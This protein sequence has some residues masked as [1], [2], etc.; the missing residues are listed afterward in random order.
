MHLRRVTVLTDRFPSRE[1]YPFNLPVLQQTALLDFERPVTFF[2]GENGSGKSTFLRG[3]AEA[4]GIY[5][6]GGERRARFDE[7]PYEGSLHRYLRV[8]WGANRV[9]GS[10]FAAESF[11]SFRQILDEW[12]T[13]DPELLEDFGSRSLMSQSH[14]QSHMAYFANRY[15]LEGI[16]FLDEP[17]NA[18]SPRRQLE[19]LEI[20]KLNAE[21]GRAQFLVA[22]HSPVLLACPGAAVL[23]FDH[24]PVQPVRYEDTDHYRVYKDLFRR[25]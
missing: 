16:Y 20:L 9:P 24:V 13:A 8:H 25:D 5:I 18:L 22:T 15:R 23:S 12:A 2:V 11:R 4:C 6:W 3:I 1:H 19:L 7:S 14:G 10:F 17:E 21:K